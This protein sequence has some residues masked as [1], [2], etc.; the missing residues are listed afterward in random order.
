MTPDTACGRTVNSA[1]APACREVEAESKV[2]RRLMGDEAASWREGAALERWGASEEESWRIDAQRLRPGR[3]SS[4]STSA[5]ATWI[6]TCSCATPQRSP[7]RCATQLE[8]RTMQ[9]AQK[10][11]EEKMRQEAAMAQRQERERPQQQ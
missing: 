7:V 4:V 6:V 3:V 8:R 5:S 11:Y 1:G 10:M 9:L 2:T